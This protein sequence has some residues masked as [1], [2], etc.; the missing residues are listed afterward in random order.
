MDQQSP[1]NLSWLE[2][3]LTCPACASNVNRFED[4]YVCMSCR[5]HYPIRFGIPDFRIAPDPYISIADEIRKIEG[6]SA[7]GR[8]FADTVKAYYELTPESPPE[9]HLHYIAAMEAAVVR[10]DALIKKLQARYP[11]AP[12]RRLLDLGCGTGGMSIAATKHY[13]QVVG[14]DVALRWLVM[15]KVRLSEANISLPLI[16]AN[17]EA[18]P[19]RSESFDAVVADA[20]LEHVRSSARMRDEAIRVLDSHGAYFFTTNNRFSILP[21]PHV[22]ILGFGLLPRRFMEPVA[23]KVRHTPYRTRLHSRRELL[24]LFKGKGDVMLP[25]YDEGE[26]GGR[27]ER[28][29]RIWET[30]RSVPVARTLLA[31]VVPQYFIA[32]QR[33]EASRR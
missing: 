20:V 18:L 14:L 31:R 13:E 30:L 11:T 19:F 33:G 15:G 12:R 22:R 9:L 2:E 16:C 4:A 26:L 24:K 21:E 5:R 32:G 17:A 1:N 7:P 27:H 25:A 8:S 29:R 10:G 6:F 3:I 23:R 28:V